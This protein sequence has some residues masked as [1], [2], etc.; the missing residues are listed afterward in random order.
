MSTTNSKQSERR[1]AKQTYW[2]S[3]SINL[4][5]TLAFLPLK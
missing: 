3:I 2:I 5:Y 1:K 4:M